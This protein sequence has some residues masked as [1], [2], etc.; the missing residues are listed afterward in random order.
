MGKY[1]K[2][3]EDEITELEGAGIVNLKGL[4][5]ALAFT[6]DCNARYVH[7]DPEKGCSIATTFD[8]CV[9]TRRL[10]KALPSEVPTS[11]ISKSELTTK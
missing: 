6:V 9:P 4:N 7:A 5:K 11:T 3:D 1:M 2:D 10:G 8:N